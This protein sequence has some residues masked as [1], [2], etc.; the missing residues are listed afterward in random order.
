[1]DKLLLTPK[2][3]AALLSIS[4]RKLRYL[5]KAGAIP[6][7]PLGRIVRYSVDD[8]Q[9]WIDRQKRQAEPALTVHSA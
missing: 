9:A 3:A 7:V 8:L 1:M 6:V 5:A 2:E 4:E